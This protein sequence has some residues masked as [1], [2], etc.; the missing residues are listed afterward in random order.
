MGSVRVSGRGRRRLEGGH[1]W[2]FADDVSHADAEP[3]ETVAVEGPHGERLG[4][5]LHSSQSK[6]RVRLFTRREEEPDERFWIERVRR[7]A[8]TRDELGLFDPRGACRLLAGDADGVPGMVIDHYAGVF[9]LQSGTQGSDRLRDVLVRALETL[10]REVRAVLDR[11]DA[12]VRRLEGLER[13]VEVLR[14]EVPAEHEIREDAPGAPSLLYEVD[15]LHGHKTGHYLD[16][17][18]NRM[19][20]AE[21]A[22]GGDVLDAFCY[23]GLFGI[24]AAL[25]GARGV[26]CLDQSEAALERARRNAERN[27]VSERVATERVDVMRDL[28]GRADLDRRF[29]L[30]IVDPPAFAKNRAELEG[31]ERGYRE[32]N[33]RALRLVESGGHLVTASCSYAMRAEPF[34]AVLARAASLSGRDVW[35]EEL[36]GASADHPVLLV[37]PESAY[38]KCAF[39]RV[40]D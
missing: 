9:V 2:V 12:S 27:G 26:L 6:I 23:D 10:G 13:R 8:A 3:G 39:L 16:Q 36:R 28:R 37:L 25:A 1:P 24:R 7:A 30:V 38:L 5:G 32:L 4:W 15:V 29:R 34:V 20:A 35:L 18:A 31:A 17:R 11:S 22:R 19:R 33:L 21:L 14:G 40:S